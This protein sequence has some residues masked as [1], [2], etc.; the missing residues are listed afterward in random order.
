LGT[1]RHCVVCGRELVTRSED[2][3]RTE[4]AHLQWALEDVPQWDA[5]SVP[6]LARGY[7]IGRYKQKE[8]VLYA[9]LEERVEPAP[10]A[11]ATLRE[12]VHGE[13]SRAAAQSN[14]SALHED[15]CDP[16]TSNKSVPDEDRKYGLPEASCGPAPVRLRA[17]VERSAQGERLK[18]VEDEIEPDADGP[19]AALLNAPAPARSIDD[20]VV[21]RASVWHRIWKPFLHESVGWFIGGFLI[22]AGTLYWVADA[23]AGMSDT[24]RSV[25]VFSFAGAWT[26]GFAAW[27]RFLSRRE[28]TRS[29]GRVLLLI[30]GAVAP[31]APVALGPIAS[32]APL[33]FWPALA[34]WSAL[35]FALGRSV[36]RAYDEAG[37]PWTAVSLSLTAAVMGVAPLVA[38]ST[39]AVWLVAA[40][41]L[42]YLASA[43]L[44]P[45]ATTGQTVFAA[46]ALLYLLAL[47][48]IRLHVA[49]ADA[50]AL[51]PPATWSPFIAAALLGALQ[52][53][54]STARADAWSVGAVGAQVA[55]TVAAATGEAP[56]LFVT[57][58]VL[59]ASALHLSRRDSRWLYPAYAGAYFAFQTCGQLVPTQLKLLLAHMRV[60]LGYAATQPLPPAYDAVYAALFV[61]A[62]GLFAW[63][64]AR[65]ERPY[66]SVLLNCTAW[67]SALVGLMGLESIVHDARPALWSAPALSAL[68]LFLGASRE[69]VS[70]TRVGAAV[71]LVAGAAVYATFGA[72]PV[73]A[74]ALGLAALSLVALK[75]HREALSAASGALALVAA[76]LAFWPV[77]GAA[78]L[79]TLALAST[80]AVLIARNLDSRE[81]LMLA[82]FGP[83]LLLPK[84]VLVVAPELFALALGVS[85][86][87]LAVV[88]RRDGRSRAALPAAWTFALLAPLVQLTMQPQ[89][90]GLLGATLLLAAL[91][92]LVG[93]RSAFADTVAIVA[94]ALA[95]I[96][97]GGVFQPLPFMTTG[98]A[99]LVAF[100]AAAGASY[101]SWEGDAR[102]WRSALVASLAL[103]LGASTGHFAIGA[104]TALVASR[105]RLPAIG[106]P[107]A[108]VLSMLATEG[109]GS[110]LL[111]L[112]LA[113]AALGLLEEFDF[114][115]VHLLGRRGIAWPASLCSALLLLAA[116]I[117]FPD[118]LVWGVC[119]TACALLWTRATRWPF[120]AAAVPLVFL[121]NFHVLPAALAV[122]ALT[123]ML[124]HSPG[125]RRA[126]L[127]D[128]HVRSAWVQGAA[129]GALTLGGAYLC[130]THGVSALPFALALLL[131]AGAPTW[132][133]VVAAAGFA[134]FVPGLPPIAAAVLLGIALLA[135]HRPV[136][137]QLLLGG[138]DRTWTVSAAALSAVGC[139][140]WAA[141]L[142]PTSLPLAAVLA[143]CLA[144][145]AVLLGLRWM[146]TAAVL[147]LALPLSL[148]ADPMLTYAQS[149]IAALVVL[150]VAA[151]AAVLRHER[152]GGQ[153]L[154]VLARVGHA[155]DGPAATPL[156]LGAALALPVVVALGAPLN[157]VTVAAAAMLLITGV[158]W[159]AAVAAL[160]L[161]GAV[162]VAAPPE[163]AGAAVAGTALMLC[164]AGAQLEKRHA[165]GRVWH[166][167]GWAL[168]LTSL[169]LLRGLDFAET[170]VAL[171]LLAACGWTVAVRRPRAEWLAWAGTLVAAHVGLFFAGLRLGHGQPP[172]LILPWA[173]LVS[174]V[175]G[176]V[177][178]GLRGT[179]RQ[180]VGAGIATLTLS[181]VELAAGALLVEGPFVREA[182]VALAAMGVAVAALG[183]YALAEDDAVVALLAQLGAALGF[184]AVRWIGFNHAPGV[185]EAF[186]ALAFGAVLGGAAGALHA[187]GRKETASAARLGAAVWPLVGIFAAPFAQ[188]WL[189]AGLLLAQAACFGMLAR[190][191]AWRHRFATLSTLCFNGALAFACLATH[192]HSPHYL[193]VPLGLSALVLLNVFKG[194][195]TPETLQRLR[196]WAV[197]VIYAA[198]AFEPLALPNPW[199]LWLCAVVCVA[200]VALGIALKVRSY[201]F[202]GTGFLVTTVVA[203]L[204]RFGI[205][206]PRVGAL[207]L[208]ALGLLIVGFMVLV[209]TRRAELLERYA[210]ARTLLAQWQG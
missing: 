41:L 56:A 17:P 202:L 150:G 122:V 131:G 58:A 77:A 115:W 82:S 123:R 174:A 53:R 196:A 118:T 104:L 186:A 158:A 55:L 173:A 166:H 50:H 121:L 183:R 119:G 200:G 93:P 192:F 9:A 195:F 16:C 4:L 81:G 128:R 169:A 101:F 130:T 164:V 31:L 33:L 109:H 153:A 37:G 23:W 83:A 157:A 208:S 46:L 95:A 125:A 156:W 96:P 105:A 12:P 142:E 116:S 110:Q 165:V 207:L 187:H 22:L 155:F 42:A 74:L 124:Q 52:L 144:L 168:A 27:A 199:A 182:F 170:P 20:E 49:L 203:S 114:S 178:L 80:A 62:G 188:P 172:Q 154:R 139:A 76:M 117:F 24:T 75:G 5:T 61:V 91:A 79:V 85:G 67:A 113:F 102:T 108:A 38:A 43:R 70:L 159:E 30:S 60:M 201:V 97:Y 143:A 44:G 141:A 71:S 66:A 40:P 138:A 47:F 179:S 160:L 120:F 86:V 84:L 149:V 190:G 167:A 175:L 11:D 209:T 10:R 185:V 68:C 19:L 163:T 181:M 1:S 98:L 90:P 94:F 13:R 193:L 34:A 63:Y 73:G 206:Q 194:D 7:V 111:V 99:S 51:P 132:W 28:A 177:A 145:C 136:A 32:A 140:A 189:V 204:T 29:A 126:L 89:V 72:V 100:A 148:I 87:A 103:L 26:L 65:R 39:S 106:V 107:F 45:R 54:N 112:A 210:R 88:A 21:E 127:G 129:A 198:A 135:R 152:V 137:A 6:A 184:V 18:E 64:P 151:L 197:T 25:T 171:A 133:R 92:M 78:G 146:L 180:R 162:A 134:L 59:C 161:A 36:S 69:R 176:A 205:Q 2:A 147:A 48:S 57:S 8:R 15:A 14:H 3:L 35:A 191:E